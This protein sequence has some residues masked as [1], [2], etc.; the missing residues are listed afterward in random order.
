M[1]KLVLLLLLTLPFWSIAQDDATSGYIIDANDVKI[2]GTVMPA[3]PDRYSAQVTFKDADG[4]KHVYRPSEIKSWGTGE[5]VYEA[6]V[7]K[8]TERT[9]HAVF[10]RRLCD[11]KGKLKVYQYWNTSGEQAYSQTFLEK[12]GVMTDVLFGRFRKFASEYFSEV[13]ELKAKIDNKE[14][15]KKDLLLMVAEYN[16]W[17]EFQWK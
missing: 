10:M 6:K 13:E 1:K 5:T 11:G 7:Y 12:D 15:K 16:Q 4:Q 14:Y 2:K 3:P 9:G 17:R 8:L